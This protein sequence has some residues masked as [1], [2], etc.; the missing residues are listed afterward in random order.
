MRQQL[1]LIKWNGDLDF[2]PSIRAIYF[3]KPLCKEKN[4]ISKI[5]WFCKKLKWMR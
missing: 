2:E 1:H 5:E 3:K 4:M